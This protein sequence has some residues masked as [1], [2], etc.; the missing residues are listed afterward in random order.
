MYFN[1]HM[2]EEFRDGTFI[3]A[4]TMHLLITYIKI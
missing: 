4:V 2:K 3:A 1:S